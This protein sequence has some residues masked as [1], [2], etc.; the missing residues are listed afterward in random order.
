MH[1]GRVIICKVTHFITSGYFKI[2]V[3][4]L[5]VV[6]LYEMSVVSACKF[7]A[8][9]HR[10]SVM[11]PSSPNT[12][13]SKYTTDFDISSRIALMYHKELYALALTYLINHHCTN[14]VLW[15][16]GFLL[17]C[18]KCVLISVMVQPGNVLS[19]CRSA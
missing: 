12:T 8:H 15:S 4:F 7:A 13:S 9:S 11:L 3:V 14:S 5:C 10:H 18:E 6:W 17:N 1:A 16:R 2:S 19:L